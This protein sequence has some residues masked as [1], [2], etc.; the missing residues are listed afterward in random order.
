MQLKLEFEV[1]RRS[2]ENFQKYLFLNWK[3]TLKLKS[4]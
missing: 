2:M 4:A 1:V 3:K